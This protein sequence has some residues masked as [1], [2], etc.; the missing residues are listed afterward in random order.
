[1]EK[2]CTGNE[3]H[4]NLYTYGDLEKSEAMKWLWAVVK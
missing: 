2:L 1:M 3:V 4:E